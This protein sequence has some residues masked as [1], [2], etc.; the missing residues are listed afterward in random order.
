MKK[1][2]NLEQSHPLFRQV[3]DYM[4]NR[5]VREEWKV[6]DKL[7][8]IRVLAEELQVHRLTVFKAYRE[9]ASSGRVYVKDKSGYYV[10]PA[11]MLREERADPN[12]DTAAV[13]VYSLTNPMSD[14]QRM[15]VK[16]QFSQALID[17]GLLPNLFLSDY[18]KKCSISIPRLWARILPSRA[19]WS[20]AGCLAGTIR[21]IT[22][23]S[24]HR[25][26]C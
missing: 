1:Q 3:Y 18:V 20:C 19:I 14:I 6:H 2:A 21:S 5:I 24:C 12:A 25:R 11:G 9:L 15:P 4:V 13:P 16:Y 26:S 22:S 17:P 8:S 23:C 10:S 7:P